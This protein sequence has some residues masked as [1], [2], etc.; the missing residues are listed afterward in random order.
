MTVK[1]ERNAYFK[2]FLG[3]TIFE[4]WNPSNNKP[5][6]FGT[7]EL[8]VTADCNLACTYCYVRRYANKLYPVD[9][10]DDKAIVRNTRLILEWLTENKLAPQTLEL[11]SGS[12]FSQ[13]V[14]WDVVDVILDVYR[15]IEPFL[16][17][18]AIVIPSNFTFVLED[19]MILRIEEYI[20]S[21]K[22]IGIRFFL[23]G[24]IEG[25]YMEQN[26]PF[27]KNLSLGDKL[28]EHLYIPSCEEPRDDDY[29]DKVFALCKKHRFGLHPMIYSKNI[30]HWKKNFLWFQE[31]LK[32]H[33]LSYNNFM[34]LE[35]RNEEWTE[36][37]CA[38]FSSFI[39]F[40]LEYI[41]ENIFHG[42]KDSFLKELKESRVLHTIFDSC[43][44][45]NISAGI[46]CALQNGMY[47]R[48]GDLHIVPCHRTSYRGLE[49]G[50]FVVEKDKIT[51]IEAINIE[52]AT[53][54]LTF[55]HK[56]L[57]MCV[58]C[59]IKEVC[60]MTCL[61]SNLETTGDLFTP[62]PSVCRLNYARILGAVRAMNK[63]GVFDEVTTSINKNQRATY[64]LL[65][66]RLLGG[67]A[68][69]K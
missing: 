43:V 38:E 8:I 61:G 15:K 42:D 24:S 55:D 37:E 19:E 12:I 51:N 32:K 3:D 40:A 30:E 52:L 13:Q 57:P 69:E 14:G 4:G 16:L 49:F 23:S 20:Q 18:K 44:S 9:I 46:P 59:V 2:Q 64:W 65:K 50:K 11:F 58:N 5:H 7:L 39:E 67:N 6:F 47:V 68:N 53:Q 31:M 27:K 41:F 36:E 62:S 66:N 48:L 56:T 45:D 26:R 54:I 1:D 35:V 34:M 21:F 63:I 25:K 17:P 33:G 28:G 10:R 29:Y 60:N 22:E